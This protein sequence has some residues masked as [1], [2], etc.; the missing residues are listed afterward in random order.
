MRAS[1]FDFVLL[2]LGAH[3]SI[4]ELVLTNNS[5]V[6]FLVLEDIIC[7]HLV[8]IVP[9]P[10]PQ[11]IHSLQGSQHHPNVHPLPGIQHPPIQCTPAPMQPTPTTSMFTRS[12]AANTHHPNVHPL[13]GIQHP[14]PQCT[15]APR[16]PTPTTS[17]YTRSQASNTHHLNVHPL[18]GSQHPPPH[19]Y[20]L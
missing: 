7:K 20:A 6:C 13:P 15:P 1:L 10:P 19:F 4:A 11:Y 3:M 5:C 17:M 18:P 2:L 14:P 9:T 8:E 16:Q 12:Q